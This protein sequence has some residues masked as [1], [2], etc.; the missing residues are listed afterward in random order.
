MMLMMV[1]VTSNVNHNDDVNDGYIDVSYDHKHGNN[2]KN[3]ADNVDGVDDE[4]NI[5]FVILLLHHLP[6]LLFFS[7]SSAAAT[8]VATT[9]TTASTSSY[10]TGSCRHV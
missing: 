9:T 6:L 4:N 3:D 8:A 2:D 1:I 10:N 7:S 5:V